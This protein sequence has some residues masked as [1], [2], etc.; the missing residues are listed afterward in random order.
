MK[1]SVSRSASSR[2]ISLQYLPIAKTPI[3]LFAYN[4]P[5][6]IG[7]TVAALQLNELAADSDLYIFSDGAKTDADTDL[8]EEVRREIDGICGFKSV[9]I[10]KRDRNC[11]LAH[12]IISG[13]SEICQRHGRVIVLEDDLVTS[14]Y[15]LRYMNDALD[16][17]ENQSDVISIHGY[18]YPVN[19]PLPDT[20]FIKGAD[21]W[22]W[23]TWRRGWDLFQPDGEILLQQL[24][25]RGLIQEFDFDGA[26][27]YSQMLRDQI[28][29]RN[30]SWAIR[31]YASA[32]LSNKLTLYPGRSLVHNIGNDSSGVHC[33]PSNFFDVEVSEA[34]VPLDKLAPLE[35]ANARAAFAHRLRGIQAPQTLGPPR[36]L[37]K[38]FESCRRAIR[39][40]RT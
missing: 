9:H 16:L 20:F 7:R 6:H 38:L 27:P 1:E 29:G 24:E 40:K 8:V 10:S 26:F 18:V 11:G 13:V 21:C 4:R 28:K 23:A 3:A 33:E 17:Y 34:P 25:R 35:N 30:N 31:W 12:S 37:A 2:Q 39:S 5:R 32:F 14:R 36:P 19:N 15:F 22:G